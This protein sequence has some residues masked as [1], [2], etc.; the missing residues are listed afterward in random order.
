VRCVAIMLFRLLPKICTTCRSI[1]CAH[2]V[3]VTSAVSLNRSSFQPNASLPRLCST[4]CQ[5][6]LI[7]HDSLRKLGLP[8][9]AHSVCVHCVETILNVHQRDHQCSST[10]E[11]PAAGRWYPQ[12]GTARCR[13][14]AYLQETSKNETVGCFLCLLT[15]C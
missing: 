13:F 12:L 10:C 7:R 1:N 9:S 8:I 4:A 6:E 5:N 15:S 11:G 14:H 3:D 2:F